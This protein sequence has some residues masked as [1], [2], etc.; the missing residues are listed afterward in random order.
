MVRRARYHLARARRPWSRSS[1]R[2]RSGPSWSARPPSLAGVASGHVAGP[3][4]TTP[5]DRSCRG[6]IS[7]GSCS[8]TAATPTRIP[9]EF[10]AVFGTPPATF[11]LAR[12]DLGEI[13]TGAD[14]LRVHGP[15]TGARPDG[16]RQQR[17]LRRLAR[18]GGAGGRRERR[19]PCRA[20]AWSGSSTLARPSP[21]RTWSPTRGRTVGTGS[22]GSPTPTVRTCCAL[23]LSRDSTD[24]RAKM[25]EDG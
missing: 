19:G 16:P 7:T 21:P 9:Q 24:D 14:P 1:H 4:S 8:T 20:R 15:A 10:D 13:P 17:G 5:M 6:S 3:S 23:A 2:S 12:V 18:R 11:G 25:R 22:A